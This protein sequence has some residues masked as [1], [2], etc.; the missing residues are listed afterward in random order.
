[1]DLSKTLITEKSNNSNISESLI[2][3]ETTFES[4]CLDMRIIKAVK[5]IGYEHPTLIQAK[6]I[7]LSLQGKDILAKARTG[8]G[9]TA[10]YTIPIVQKILMAKQNTKI[11][12]S[13]GAGVKAVILVPTKELCEQ[14]QQN[15]LQIC[16]YCTHLINVVHLGSEQSVDEQRGMLRDVPDIIIST[17]TRLVNHLKNQNI[18]LDMS[19][20]ML[21]IDEADLVLSYGYQEDIQTIKSFLPKVCQGFL[22]S[23]TLTPQVDEL[24]KLILHTP[25]ILRLEEDQSEKTNLTEYSIKTV[26][27]DR[28]LLIFTLLR[29][30][31]M[32][33]KILFFVNDTFQCYKLK[34]FL[35]QFHIRAAVLNSE[36]P[37]NSRHHII[38]QFNKGIYD[39]LIATDES[40]KSTKSELKDFDEIDSEE[41]NDQDDVSQ[42][43]EEEDNDEDEEDNDED[44]EEEEEEEDQDSD[45][46]NQDQDSDDE[47]QE[48]PEKSTSKKSIQ[49]KE[50]PKESEE[51]QEDD[52]ESENDEDSFFSKGEEMEVKE[53][54]EEEKD[55]KP[56]K[57]ADKEYGVARGIDFKNVD[58]VINFD[59]PRTYKN[60][61]HR[62]GRTARGN[63]KGVALSFVTKR[64][65]PLLKKIQRKRAE[66]G[67]NVKPFEFKMA[68]IEGFRYRVEDVLNSVT[69]NTISR[70]RKTELE[71]EIINSEKLKNHFKENPKDL[72]ILKHDIPLTRKHDLKEHLG[73]I[74][75]YLVP[76]ALKKTVNGKSSSGKL[77]IIKSGR[78]N[79]SNNNN[80]K[81]RQSQN[82]KRKGN[83]SGGPVKLSQKDVNKFKGE[84]TTTTAAT[85]GNRQVKKQKK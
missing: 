33:G 27:F 50:E 43:E 15:L 28:Y 80:N 52:E 54:E 14:V 9:K 62:V 49:V 18:K 2:D 23:A 59:F 19:L 77:P 40:F 74:P 20:E 8:S 85:S 57:L 66:H 70:A 11:P 17:P 29:L 48:I 4:M 83:S 31:L 22:M 45:E 5:K 34:L 72:E 65:E 56:S 30:K 39:Y 10:A 76:D 12:S 68:T 63:S 73:Y 71:Q 78:G 55:R 58:I 53:E 46:E 69:K 41:E 51:E 37:I 36:L 38:L 35:E 13:K 67:Y 84:S 26:S 60:Y 82:K 81:N 44:E 24:K 7:P 3:G 1:M 6:S 79:S 21:V 47:V 25:A 16:F 64:N 32:Q 42:D 61:V 75:E